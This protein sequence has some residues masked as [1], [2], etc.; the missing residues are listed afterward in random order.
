MEGTLLAIL[1]YAVYT[2]GFDIKELE[3]ALFEMLERDMDGA[4]FGINRTFIYAFNKN[5]KKVS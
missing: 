2:L 3:I 1:T 4:H 5:E